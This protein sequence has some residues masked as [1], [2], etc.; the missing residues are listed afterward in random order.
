[1]VET[2]IPMAPRASSRATID[3]VIGSPCV[4]QQPCEESWLQMAATSAAWQAF[5]CGFVRLERRQAAA[6]SHDRTPAA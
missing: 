1:L 5:C 4:S 2:A 3:Q 6:A